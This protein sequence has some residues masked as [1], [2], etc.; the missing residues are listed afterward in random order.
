[1]YKYTVT[2]EAQYVSADTVSIINWSFSN[3]VV[4]TGSPVNNYYL[5]TGTYTATLIVGTLYGCQDT[6]TKTI[7][8]NQSPTITASAD[9]TICKG[10]SKQLNVTGTTSYAW[11]PIDGSLNCI[12]CTNPIAKPLTTTY[13]VVTGT[14]SFGC[15]AIDT[16]VITVAQPI[17][18]TVS[19]NDTI[20]IGQ[21]S[22]LSVTGATTYTWSP[23]LTLNNTTTAFPTATPTLTTRYRVIGFDSY[24]CFQDTAYVTVAVGQYPTV[25]LGADKVL[26][27]GTPLPLV[28]TITNGPITKWTCDSTA[29][30]LSCNDCPTPIATIKR[31]ICYAVEVANLYKCTARDTM[32]VKVFCENAQVFIPNAFTPDGDGV[33]DVL[34]VRA[35]GIRSVKNFRIFNRWGQLVFEKNNFNPNDVSAGWDGLINGKL[36]SPDVYVYMC[37]V[38]CEN[39][40]IYT[41][42]GN[43]SI[44]K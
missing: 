33:N 19:P 2:Y 1:L 34:M 22:Q 25:N 27:T 40:V 26:A 38:V 6:V 8:I 3:G 31:E 11:S 5:N 41:Y 16:V 44:V 15:T 7:S 14:N 9:A 18:I 17:D 36:A 29:A 37:E 28:T 12:S 20:C 30:T 39:D 23:G 35:Q 21:S 4:L 32:C 13:Y 43:V 10:Q 24:N 42:K